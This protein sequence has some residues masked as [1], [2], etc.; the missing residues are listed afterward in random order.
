AL[1]VAVQPDSTRGGSSVLFVRAPDRDGLFAAI[2]ATL[3][4]LGLD[5]VDARL[6]ASDRGLVFDTFE[7]LDAATASALT[8]ERSAELEAELKRVLSDARLEPGIARRT[9]PRRLRHFQRAPQIGF[10]AV[11]AATQLALVCIDRPG[12][13]AQ[14]AQALRE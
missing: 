6:L 4:R 1:V 5:V 10:N 13:L 2:A 9:L 8:V 3:D 14:V 11:G 12:L 7:L